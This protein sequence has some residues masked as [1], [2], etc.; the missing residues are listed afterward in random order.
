MMEASKFY[1]YQ[2]RG[3]VFSAAAERTYTR[4]DAD[5]QKTCSVGL[6]KILV[7]GLCKCEIISYLMKNSC[8]CMG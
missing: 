4:V 8:V 6:R 3:K 2:T 7:E 5:V 1:T